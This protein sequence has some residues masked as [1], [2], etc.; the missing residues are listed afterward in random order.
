MNALVTGA[1]GFIGRYLC[2]AL[3]QKGYNVS[4]M[5]IADEKPVWCDK[6]FKADITRPDDNLSSACKDIDVVFH[7]AGKV[8]ALPKSKPISNSTG[9]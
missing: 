7:L 2:L 9:W 8:H 6:Y 3:A 5:D 4:G 1:N